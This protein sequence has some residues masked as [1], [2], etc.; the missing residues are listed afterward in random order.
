MTN[1]DLILMF[2]KL[3]RH[4]YTFDE[5]QDYARCIDDKVL[6]RLYCRD[7]GNI[8]EE[9]LYELAFNTIKLLQMLDYWKI[10]KGAYEQPKADDLDT[11]KDV[12]V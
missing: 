6:R 7:V 2:E 1:D 9:D 3:N 8:S 11:L 5:I 4:T 10:T 12:E